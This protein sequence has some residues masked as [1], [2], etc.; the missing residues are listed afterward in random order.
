MSKPLLSQGW[1]AP[2]KLNLMLNI[3]GQRAD[4]YH[5][6]Q[7]V[8]QLLDFGDHLDFVI[9]SDAQ[10]KRQAS[11]ADVEFDQDL[12]IRAARL[13]QRHSG[14][15][16]GVRIKL[17]K[18]L[19]MGAGLGG[20]SSDAATVL[21]A[22]NHLWQLGLGVQ[23]LAALGLRLGADVPLFVFGYSSWAEGVGEKL[24]PMK[25]PAAWYL[26]LTPAVQVSTQ[27]IF[28]AEDLT[29]NSSPIKIRDFLDGYEQND[30]QASVVSRYP[31][32]AD[33]LQW[34]SQH[35]PARLT[36]TGSSVFAAFAERQQ[37]EQLLAE[38]PEHWQAFV[39]RGV[40]RSP[41]LRF[42]ER[43]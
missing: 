19:P 39:A 36:G 2:A 32:V 40:N 41:L 3:I 20:G 28:A 22:L 30:C 29:R 38:L 42:L 7:S 21:V 5:L 31:Q 15:P 12:S 9:T 18:C 33:A 13:L 25:L 35:A 43:V 24:Q 6:L 14:C 10:I 23:E 34:L 8:F 37:A 4:G 17:H 11:V 27:T 1:P 16:L 26:V